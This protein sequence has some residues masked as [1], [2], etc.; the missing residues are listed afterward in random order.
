MQVEITSILGQRNFAIYFEFTD[1]VTGPFSPA[2]YAPPAIPTCKIPSVRH[3]NPM[4]TL[5]NM[6]IAYA[7]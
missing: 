4:A 3:A 6:A 7:L 2:I 5:L 1:T